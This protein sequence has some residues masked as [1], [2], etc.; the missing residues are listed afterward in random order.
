MELAGYAAGLEVV[1]PASV[2]LDLAAIG[3]GLVE[4]YPDAS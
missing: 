3:K 1:E 2:R 4:R